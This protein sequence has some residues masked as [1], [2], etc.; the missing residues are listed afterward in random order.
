M[1]LGALLLVGTLAQFYL[2]YGGGQDK[3]VAEGKYI[4]I[5]LKTGEITQRA[6]EASHEAEAAPEPVAEAPPHEVP[7]TTPAAPEHPVADAVHSGEHPAAPAEQAHTPPADATAPAP[8]EAPAPVAAATPQEAA[9]PHEAAPPVAEGQAAVP[10]AAPPVASAK[11]P[12][13]KPRVAVVMVGLGLSRSSTEA[14]LELPQGVALSFSPYAFDLA[15]WMDKAG[16]A[17]E[18][19]IDLPLEPA[20]YPYSDPGPFALLTGQEEAKNQER[21]EQILGRATGYA[22]L[23]SGADERFTENAT[24]FTPLLTLLK[25]KGLFY[26]YLARNE[27]YRLQQANDAIGASLLGADFLIDKSLSSDG[28]V[29]ALADMEKKAQET[30][31]AVGMARPYPVT[32]KQLQLWAAGLAAKGIELVPLSTLKPAGHP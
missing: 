11:S 15:Q 14:A 30:G 7:A 3:A 26:V 27:N 24:S 19:Y 23:V 29:T 28:I 12:N 25:E 18:R 1:I 21:L 22:G 9:H 32:I 20:D 16:A 8:A 4:E 17:R 6:E 10:A 13:R 2:A 5:D 31:Y